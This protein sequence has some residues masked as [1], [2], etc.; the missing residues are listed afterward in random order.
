MSFCISVTS[1][2]GPA[3]FRNELGDLRRKGLLAEQG[4]WLVLTREALLKV[5][6]LL[7]AFFLPRHRGARYT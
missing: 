7:H 5:D 1:P 4:D 2:R 3:D 6:T